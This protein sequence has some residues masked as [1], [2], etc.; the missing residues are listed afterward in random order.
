[1]CLLVVRAT[2]HRLSVTEKS[3]DDDVNRVLTIVH[4]EETE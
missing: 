2:S 1:M 3:M 4:F